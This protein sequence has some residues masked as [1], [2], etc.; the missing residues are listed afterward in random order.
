MKLQG[1]QTI[2]AIDLTDVSS[3][4]YLLPY[5]VKMPSLKELTLC[6]P[7]TTSGAS[8]N[9]VKD[10]SDPLSKIEKLD[11]S[12]VSCEGSNAIVGIMGTRPTSVTALMLRGVDMRLSQP[13]V[14]FG[15]VFKYNTTLTHLDLS[16]TK[17]FPYNPSSRPEFWKRFFR[18][19]RMNETLRVLILAN[20]DLKEGRGTDGIVKLLRKNKGLLRLDIQENGFESVSIQQFAEAICRNENSRLEGLNFTGLGAW[21]SGTLDPEPSLKLIRKCLSNWVTN[22]EQAS[23]RPNWSHAFFLGDN[24]EVKGLIQGFKELQQRTRSND[25]KYPELVKFAG[26]PRVINGVL[27]SGDFEAFY[28]L[29]ELNINWKEARFNL[30]RREDRFGLIDPATWGTLHPIH[31]ALLGGELEL[32]RA[33]AQ[34]GCD[35][36]AVTSEGFSLVHLAS[37]LGFDRILEWLLI[38]NALPPNQYLSPY[39]MPIHLAAMGRRLDCIRVLHKVGVGL[40]T[41]H[42]LT[43]V[44]PLHLA[45]EGGYIGPKSASIKD[46]IQFFDDHLCN[47]DVQDVEGNTPLHRALQANNPDLI[48]LLVDD[49]NVNIDIPNA[50]GK[51]QL[52]LA[53]SLG[54]SAQLRKMTDIANEKTSL[55]PRVENL[56]FEGGGVKGLV[57]LSAYRTAVDNGL[58]DPKE[59]KRFGGASAGSITALLLCLDPSLKGLEQLEKE[60][61]ELDYLQ[62]LDSS[63]QNVNNLAVGGLKAWKAG[64][65]GIGAYLNLLNPF[66][67]M[68]AA[69]SGTAFI[70]ELTNHSGIFQGDA[71]LSWIRRKVAMG[72]RRNNQNLTFKELY[73]LCQ[74]DLFVTTVDLDE[75][76]SKTLSRETTPDMPVADAVRMSISI[77]LAFRPHFEF[78]MVRSGNTVSREQIG[79]HRYVDG[80]VLENYPIHLFDRSRYLHRSFRV[81]R[82]RSVFNERTLGFRIMPPTVEAS[83]SALKSD[84]QSPR[85]RSMPALLNFLGN[86]VSA[87][88][89]KEESDYGRSNNRIRTIELSSGGVGTMDFFLGREERHLLQSLGPIGVKAY[90]QRR[91][92]E[93]NEEERHRIESPWALAK[94]VPY[95]SSAKIEVTHQRE[96]V[97]DLKSLPPI[98]ALQIVELFKNAKTDELEGI[99]KLG[100]PLQNRHNGETA[101]HIA[102][103]DLKFPQ[104]ALEALIRGGLH[105][106]A[107]RDNDKKTPIDL[108]QQFR[109]STFLETLRRHGYLSED[110]HQGV[111]LPNQKRAKMEAPL[112]AEKAKYQGIG[113][114]MEDPGNASHVIAALQIFSL[115]PFLSFFLA[116]DQ[117]SS[118]SLDAVR[119]VVINYLDEASGTK[120]PVSGKRISTVL[121]KAGGAKSFLDL[122]KSYWHEFDFNRKEGLSC[123]FSE[124]S[125]YDQQHTPLQS[126]LDWLYYNS[127]F[128]SDVLALGLIRGGS[129]GQ[130]AIRESFHSNG[131][132]YN[133]R[134]VVLQCD[135]SRYSVLKWNEASKNWV[136]YYHEVVEIRTIEKFS[137]LASSKGV[138]FLYSAE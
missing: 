112:G 98:T 27:S 126:I 78:R 25:W 42:L 120:Q 138:L 54:L 104:Y 65:I 82:N 37:M 17:L 71:L 92:L 94:L 47:F 137:L 16:R 119:D 36:K 50:S 6:G 70:S 124:I 77:P 130:F 8:L 72:S 11:I 52:D 40:E 69:Q 4:A 86:L 5:L 115:P 24:K 33:V 105:P 129:T 110:S 30:S 125:Q 95:L 99:S 113:V 68:G 59:I 10:L 134:A 76:S 28:C 114:G 43:G 15:Q 39:G 14:L 89:H 136:E 109:N 96:L 13:D 22:E 121:E 117:T 108:A 79:N 1:N 9:F 31:M 116:P 87:I 118:G 84:P 64:G 55:L 85:E 29:N 21:H 38:E 91:Q 26:Q 62:W 106:H 61:L 122:F 74:R 83:S 56:V 100:L 107:Q 63:N 34:E 44:T 48:E 131:R 133:L 101:L 132:K 73:D 35:L 135:N 123:H 75:G 67:L 103:R 57:Y 51:S 32:L 18:E 90:L 20:C 7:K 127:S 93:A 88:Y 66:A 12:L 102:A 60:L 2:T 46:S 58:F 41:P 49:F 45:C 23:N 53:R 80:G 111:D 3:A 128:Q 97:V 81:G 19:L